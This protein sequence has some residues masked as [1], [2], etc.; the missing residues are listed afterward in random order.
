M[1]KYVE[2]VYFRTYLLTCDIAQAGKY[3][4]TI[5]VQLTASYTTYPDY[6][7]SRFP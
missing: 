1:P 6:T 3:V 4:P 2:R 5:Y 7:D